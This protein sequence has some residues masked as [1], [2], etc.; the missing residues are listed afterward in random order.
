M[1]SEIETSVDAAELLGDDVAETQQAPA[2][3]AKGA[4]TP[5]PANISAQGMPKRV[6]IILEENEDIPP[7]GLPIGHN[8]NT[9]VIMPGEPV[10]VPEFLLEI[11]DNAVMSGPQKDPQTQ[12]VVGWRDRLRFPYRRV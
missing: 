12:R 1:E 8:G 10:E 4:K 9:Y 2:K 5:K 11:L 3:A 6:K 7:T